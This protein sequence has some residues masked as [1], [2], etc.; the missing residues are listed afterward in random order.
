MSLLERK[1]VQDSLFPSVLEKRRQFLLKEKCKLFGYLAQE[2]RNTGLD[3][4]IIKN[5]IH[6]IS[7]I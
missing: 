7:L 6:V 4:L 1:V 2:L 3:M 5:I